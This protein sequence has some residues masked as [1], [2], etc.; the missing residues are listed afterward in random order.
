MLI[1]HLCMWSQPQVPPTASRAAVHVRCYRSFSG[2]VL[3]G[4]PRGDSMLSLC[5]AEPASAPPRP[6][7]APPAPWEPLTLA[8]EP[9]SSCERVARNIETECNCQD[10]VAAAVTLTAMFLADV[11]P[12]FVRGDDGNKSS[13]AW[14]KWVTMGHHRQ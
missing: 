14:T 1:D 7:L 3:R 8:D 11:A 13:P 10:R 6:R 9:A 2:G 4:V 5:L 12:V